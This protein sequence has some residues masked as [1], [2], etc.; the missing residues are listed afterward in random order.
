MSSRAIRLVRRRD[1]HHVPP[2]NPSLTTP[3]K[4]RVRRK[5]HMAYHR[6]FSNAGSLEQCIEILKR[7]WWPNA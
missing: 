5:D 7:D 3:I 2:R 6:L 4:I 1:W